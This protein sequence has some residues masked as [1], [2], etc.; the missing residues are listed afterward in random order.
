LGHADVQ[1]TTTKTT[2]NILD[3]AIWKFMVFAVITQMHFSSAEHGAWGGS[4]GKANGTI[5]FDEVWW[6]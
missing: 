1:E 6:S 4:C 3:K 2:L 5:H